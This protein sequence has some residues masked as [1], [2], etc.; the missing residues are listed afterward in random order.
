MTF[1]LL[2][3]ASAVEAL[4]FLEMQYKVSLDRKW[5]WHTH[6]DPVVL[7][8]QVDW[9]CCIVITPD[10]I[11]KY[12]KVRGQRSESERATL[13]SP[14]SSAG[15]SLAAAAAEGFLGTQRHL[16]PAEELCGPGGGATPAAADGSARAAALCQRDARLHQQP[17]LLPLLGRAGETDATGRGCGIF[18]GPHQGPP[19]IH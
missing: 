6:C 15:V 7:S 8:P 9:P 11:A 1:D 14:V 17:A 2:C 5:V 18:G 16:L 19:A 13:C 4:D 10:S 3:T 12:N